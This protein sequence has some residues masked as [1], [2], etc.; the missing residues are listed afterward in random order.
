MTSSIITPYKIQTPSRES[1]IKANLH[2]IKQRLLE[3]NPVYQI[4]EKDLNSSK[5]RETLPH[6]FTP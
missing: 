6:Q 1:G 3:L 5:T 2:P 4:F